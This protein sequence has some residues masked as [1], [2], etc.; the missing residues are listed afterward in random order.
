MQRLI[1]AVGVAAVSLTYLGG[2]ASA[3]D[4][5]YKAPPAAAVAPPP[6]RAHASNYFWDYGWFTGYG[7]YDTCA[8]GARC[9]VGP[10]VERNARGRVQFGQYYYGPT[11]GYYHGW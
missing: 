10:P 3:A 6:E 5:V 4:M 1:I 8:G 11:G 7:P 2:Y 9:Y